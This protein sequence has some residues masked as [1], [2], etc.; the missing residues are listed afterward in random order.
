[1]EREPGEGVTDCPTAEPCGTTGEGRP[2]DSLR[3]PSGGPSSQRELPHN[4]RDCLG[5]CR[6]PCRQRCPITDP[7]LVLETSYASSAILQP[8]PPLGSPPG[9]Q[10]CSQEFSPG[11]AA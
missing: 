9:S 2:E 10:K 3:S 8:A 7:Q 6:A 11:E 1:M 5:M 4:G